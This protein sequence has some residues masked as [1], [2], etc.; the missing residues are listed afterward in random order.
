[1]SSSYNQRLQRLQTAIGKYEGYVEDILGERRWTFVVDIVV[2]VVISVILSIG[3]LKWSGIEGF[4]TTFGLGGLNA[5]ERLRQ[6][7]TKLT[8]YL[9]ERSKL[10]RTIRTLKIKLDLCELDD[11]PN[12]DCLKEVE[13]LLRQYLNALMR[14]PR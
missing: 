7:H 5:E 10:K 4:A 12:I 2:I 6:G 9:G 14:A 13:N 3:A 11:P 8:S 1:M